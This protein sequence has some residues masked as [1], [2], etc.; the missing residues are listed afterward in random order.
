MFYDKIS[1][2]LLIFCFIFVNGIYASNIKDLLSDDE[3]VRI[4]A[5]DKLKNLSN[6][7]KEKTFCKLLQNDENIS[8]HKYV[9][10]AIKIIQI[11]NILPV[12]EINEANRFCSSINDAYIIQKKT[13]QIL[14]EFDS[15][16]VPELIKALDNNNDFMISKYASILSQIGES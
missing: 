16:S 4:S 2:F 12:L 7:S 1:N 3:H 14:I 11:A 10:Q 8:T 6:E 13:E 9:L 5:Q 15:L